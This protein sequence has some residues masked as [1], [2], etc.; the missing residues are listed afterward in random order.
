[1][2]KHKCNNQL[3]CELSIWALIYKIHIQ[4]NLKDKKEEQMFA[5]DI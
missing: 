5:S 4:G 3:F 1:M 2:R